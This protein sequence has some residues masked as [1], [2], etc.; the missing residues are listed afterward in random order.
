VLEAQP[1]AG[2]ASLQPL[3]GHVFVTVRVRVS[4]RADEVT[5]AVY[6]PG[7]DWRVH[8][9]NLVWYSDKGGVV[10]EPTL[11]PAW[12]YKGLVYGERPI[13]GW[14][15]FELPA[16]Q[17]SQLWLVGIDGFQYRLF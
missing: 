14:V 16:S 11:L 2:T 9:N 1:W 13:E 15:T 7:L 6:Y 5:D 17:A 12:V 8:T 10:R 4:I 3:A